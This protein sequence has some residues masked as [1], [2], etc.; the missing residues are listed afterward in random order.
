MICS[1]AHTLYFPQ[2]QFSDAPPVGPECASYVGGARGHLYPC[3]WV[4]REEAAVWVPGQ[5]FTLLHHQISQISLNQLFTR[6][7]LPPI[8][9]CLSCPIWTI[10]IFPWWHPAWKTQ[11]HPASP[12]SNSH[13]TSRPWSPRITCQSSGLRREPADGKQ[14]FSQDCHKTLR[15]PL[16][17]WIPSHAESAGTKLDSAA[18]QCPLDRV[19]GETVPP[20]V[21]T[22]KLFNNLLK[23]MAFKGKKIFILCIYC[24]RWQEVLNWQ[25]KSWHLRCITVRR[26]T[27]QSIF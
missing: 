6:C 3:H 5:S 11:P 15:D 4:D 18:W 19:T 16:P 24:R 8:R 25:K 23:V 14:E 10:Y 1:V 17:I 7:L 2:V 26:L 27:D 20:A 21:K 9:K 22:T 13:R 12:Q